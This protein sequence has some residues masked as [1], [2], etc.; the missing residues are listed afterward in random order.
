MNI[1]KDWIL[2]LKKRFIFSSGWISAE[3]LSKFG[4]TCFRLGVQ[5]LYKWRNFY[6]EQ[7]KN[8]DIVVVRRDDAT[9][10]HLYKIAMYYSATKT[11][12]ELHTRKTIKVTSQTVWKLVKTNE[13]LD[14]F[15]KE[16]MMSGNPCDADCKG[17]QETQK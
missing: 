4:E 7:P 9:E 3:N 15:D 8:Y 2:Q 1:S 12:V 11:L 14:K 5:Y 13:D 10:P 6:I 17:N 16:S